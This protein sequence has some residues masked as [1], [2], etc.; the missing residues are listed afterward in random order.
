MTTEEAKRYALS[1][2]AAWI[3]SFVHDGLYHDD[4]EEFDSPEDGPVVRGFLGE[5][6][7]ELLKRAGVQACRKCGCSELDACECDG[8]G[9]S[10][11]EPDLCSACAELTPARRLIEVVAR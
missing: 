8:G 1:E 10:W 2:A 11:I 6:A 9:C 7:G 4:F 5:I 3:R